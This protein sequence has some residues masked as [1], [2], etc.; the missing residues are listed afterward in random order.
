[1][2]REGPYEEGPH[3]GGGG[4]FVGQHGSLGLIAE[5]Q[6]DEAWGSVWLTFVV[7]LSI[8]KSRVMKDM[9]ISNRK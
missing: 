7:I 8:V 9:W 5:S 4:D 3:S 2:F 1:M 6:K